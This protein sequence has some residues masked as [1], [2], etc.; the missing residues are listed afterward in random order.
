MDES[1]Q[2]VDNSNL[3]LNTK[4]LTYQNSSNTV[5]GKNSSFSV[6]TNIGITADAKESKSNNNK[7]KINSST[8][9][10]SKDATYSKSKT[11]ATLGEGNVTVQDTENS[12]DTTRLNRDTQNTTKEIYD[13]KTG[14]TIDMT[15]DHR[16]LS[17]EGR[18]QIKEDYIKSAFIATAL[19]EAATTESTG[20]VGDK[21]SGVT[22][23][24]QN[25]EDKVA[26]FDGTKKFVNDP[27]NKEARDILLNPNATLQEIKQAQQK[28]HVYVANE[29]GIT[30]TELEVILDKQYKGF[31][32]SQDG[33]IKLAGNLHNNMGD[34]ANTTINETSDVADL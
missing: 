4:T 12:D 10:F 3:T 20:I 18:K 11:L 7:V 25:I 31:T 26:L 5:Y 32:S 21:A 8:V 30:P 14:V 1:G 33:K 27:Q 22:G 6:G 17:E 28:L 19:V 29:M 2:F 15:L 34:M 16:L 9:N 13:A 24:F 23:I